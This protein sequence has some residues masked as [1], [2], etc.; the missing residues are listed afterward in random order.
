MGD[1]WLPVAVSWKLPGGSLGPSRQDASHLSLSAQGGAGQSHWGPSAI[2]FWL[3]LNHTLHLSSKKTQALRNALLS[4][5]GCFFRQ[6]TSDV[7][8]TFSQDAKEESLPI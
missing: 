5:R 4:Y 6:K 2:P 3:F 8:V 1:G 7:T